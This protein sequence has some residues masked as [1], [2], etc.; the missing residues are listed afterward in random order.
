MNGNNIQ[1]TEELHERYLS[2]E[3]VKDISIQT[4]LSKGCLYKRFERLRK[5]QQQTQVDMH[6]EDAEE[7]GFAEQTIIESENSDWEEDFMDAVLSL[8]IIFLCVFLY[9]KYDREIM[10]R[11]KKSLQKQ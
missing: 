8:A 1:S 7:T 2:G 5:T 4:G 11:L 6:N 3:K 10:I 9:R